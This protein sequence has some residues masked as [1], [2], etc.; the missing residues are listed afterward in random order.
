[1]TNKLLL[2]KQL[3]EIWTNYTNCVEDKLQTD[4]IIHPRIIEK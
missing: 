2:K 4:K 3:L 1:M